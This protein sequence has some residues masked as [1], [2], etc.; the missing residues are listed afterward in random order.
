MI[1]VLF[2]IPSA[3]NPIYINLAFALLGLVVI[4][5]SFDFKS[6]NKRNFIKSLSTGIF[7]FLLSVSM[8]VY[9]LFFV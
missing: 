1:M 9:N 4:N 6:Q 8:A 7:V 3:F 5:K 2:V